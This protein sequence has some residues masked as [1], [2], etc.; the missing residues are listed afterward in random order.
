M[1]PRA[2]TWSGEKDMDHIFFGATWKWV[3]PCIM[4]VSDMTGERD[5]SAFTIFCSLQHMPWIFIKQNFDICRHCCHAVAVNFTIL[6]CLSIFLLNLIY[7]LLNFNEMN[8]YFTGICFLT[9]G[10][11]PLSYLSLGGTGGFGIIAS[12]SP[13]D[14]KQEQ[15]DEI[16]AKICLVRSNWVVLA[17]R[18]SFPEAKLLP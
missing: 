17:S 15:D 6:C 16:K 7:P 8:T 5:F 11:L 14:L 13:R 9:G 1:F 10:G 18:F 12:C 2:R 3:M 4:A